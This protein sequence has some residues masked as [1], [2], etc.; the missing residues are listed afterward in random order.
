MNKWLIVLFSVFVVF[1]VFLTGC[2][3][4]KK[5]VEEI[6]TLNHLNSIGQL[7]PD[8]FTR[9]EHMLA[10]DPMAIAELNEIKALSADHEYYH[11][12]HGLSSLQEY[13]ETGK[14]DLCPAHEL[15]HY[16]VFMRHNQTYVNLEE[17]Q[18]NFDRWVLL[19]QQSNVS[20]S[21]IERIQ[22]HLDQ[23]N[24]GNTSASDDEIDWLATD[25]NIC[26]S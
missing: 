5:I 19:A 4:N 26:M 2:S 24:S 11:V 10:Y 17:V 6:T 13:I 25:G 18:G 7:Y 21:I 1:L 16:Y 8:N 12:F 9:L 22:H 15:A 3:S 20:N 23:I 14:T